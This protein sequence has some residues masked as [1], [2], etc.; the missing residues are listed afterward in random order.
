MKTLTRSFLPIITI[1]FIVHSISVIQKTNNNFLEEKQFFFLF[2]KKTKLWYGH[3]KLK[4]TR[5]FLPQWKHFLRLLLSICLLQTLKSN[6]LLFFVCLFVCTQNNKLL[7]CIDFRWQLM[8]AKNDS[9]KSFN[10]NKTLS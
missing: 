4:F 5:C 10:I 6:S 2:L 9:K 1:F 3:L 7:R 8:L